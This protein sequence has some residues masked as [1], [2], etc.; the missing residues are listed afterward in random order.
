MLP[1]RLTVDH[2]V[3][4]RYGDS[5]GGVAGAQLSTCIEKVLMDRVFADPED[6]ADFPRGFS[7]GAPAHHFALTWGQFVAPARVRFPVHSFLLK[8]SSWRPPAA[9]AFA[10]GRRA[11]RF[12]VPAS[13]C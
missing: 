9:A 6:A 4:D 12:L 13:I 5:M 11:R 10:G 3:K 8:R 1:A 2:P 7:R